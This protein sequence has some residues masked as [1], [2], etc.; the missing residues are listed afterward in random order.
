MALYSYEVA[1]I[2][3]NIARE[4]E[5][6]AVTEIGEGTNGFG[7]KISFT[8]EE[9][10]T[11]SYFVKSLSPFGFGNELAANRLQRM[12]EAAIPYENSIPVHAVLALDEDG[13]ILGNLLKLTEAVTISQ[14]LPDN[15]KNLLELLRSHPLYMEDV[16]NSAA[17]MAQAMVDIHSAEK[18]VGENAEALYDRSTR[19]I[20]HN[21]EL[22]P[23]VWDFL[24]KQNPTWITPDEY[25]LF[26][27]NMI[28]TRENLSTDASRMT[29]VQ[30][31]YWAANVFTTPD[32]V[33]IT[34][35]R[36]VWGEPAIDAAWMIGEFCMQNLLRYGQFAGPITN[37]VWSEIQNYQHERQDWNLVNYMALP[38]S[39]QAFAE[40]TFTPDLTDEQRRTLFLAGFGALLAAQGGRPFTAEHLDL[41]VSIAKDTLDNLHER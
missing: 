1:E 32:E 19:S 11:R 21:E 10:K 26:V 37:A 2:A 25:A 24:R 40:A 12:A 4:G 41:Y 18:F 36:T 5:T 34:D 7:F 28:L 13:Q 29:R 33:L 15:A 23:G 6:I 38:Y 16:E 9:G 8:N 22:T 35:S 30:G 20:I 17:L 3:Q 14:I 39:F 31:D 27:Q